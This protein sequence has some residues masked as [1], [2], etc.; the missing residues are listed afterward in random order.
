M[1]PQAW[2]PYPVEEVFDGR[3][4]PSIGVGVGI[5]IGIG[6]LKM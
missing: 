3:L 6:F 5:G 1:S 4:K 2:H